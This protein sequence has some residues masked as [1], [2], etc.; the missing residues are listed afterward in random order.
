MTQI[1]LLRDAAYVLNLL[2]AMRMIPGEL[3]FL[4]SLEKLS[5]VLVEYVYKVARSPTI[6][7]YEKVLDMTLS[8]LGAAFAAPT[9]SEVA[10]EKILEYV[11]VLILNSIPISLDNSNYIYE[12]A[13]KD[14]RCND[15]RY[16]LLKLQVFLL[17][18]AH[19][20]PLAIFAKLVRML[21]LC[22]SPAD[23]LHARLSG[24]E[25]SYYYMK[26]LEEIE[27]DD[28]AGLYERELMSRCRRL[29]EVERYIWNLGIRK[30]WITF[31]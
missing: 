6:K 26:L 11:T 29:D 15:V 8:T 3:S 18:Y 25:A 5:Y 9:L 20:P 19:K 31:K 1:L 24:R 17:S 7:M 23:D 28:R 14:E 13:N 16:G 30:N 2:I 4:C 10:N 12:A 27:V 21:S 22:L